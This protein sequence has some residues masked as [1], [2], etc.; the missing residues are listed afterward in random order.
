M[1]RNSR[2]SGNALIR[3]VAAYNLI[4]AV[5]YTPYKH[6]TVLRIIHV[7]HWRELL[8]WWWC[9]TASAEKISLLGIECVFMPTSSLREFM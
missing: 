6:K 1:A 8:S 4:V 5:E 7:T 3:S 9:R 2:Y